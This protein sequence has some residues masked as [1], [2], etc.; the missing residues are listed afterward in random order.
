[1]KQILS[2]ELKK[3]FRKEALPQLVLS[4]VR[5]DVKEKAQEP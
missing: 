3:G 5:V 4:Y 2:G 1:M